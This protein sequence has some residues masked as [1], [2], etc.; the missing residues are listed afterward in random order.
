M[1]FNYDLRFAVKKWTPEQEKQY[2]A[3]G[4]ITAN[5]SATFSQ[6]C[7]LGRGGK[8]DGMTPPYS[9]ITLG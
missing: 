7:S 2:S 3:G 4:S 5:V 9:Y 8:R 1:V 6:S